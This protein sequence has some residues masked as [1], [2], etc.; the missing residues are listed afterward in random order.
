MLDGLENIVAAL[1]AADLSAA[2]GEP[3]VSPGSVD[4]GDFISL[5]DISSVLDHGLLQPPYAQLVMQSTRLP[6]GKLT[7]TAK[8]SDGGAVS[9]FDGTR[10]S[11]ALSDGYTLKLNQVHHWHRRTAAQVRSLEKHLPA[12]VKP[13]VFLTPAAEEALLPH[14]D[15]SHVLVVQLEGRKEWSLW[16]PTAET[17]SSY[18]LDVDVAN[19]AQHPVL[20]PGD[21][22]YLPHGF[23]HAARAVGGPSLHITFTLTLPTP[24]TIVDTLLAE[25]DGRSRSSVQPYTGRADLIRDTTEGMRRAILE[26]DNPAWFAGALA[27]QRFEQESE[28]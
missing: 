3:V 27:R 21:V 23:P 6:D 14:R 1:S 15:A 19:P 17:R 4:V 16:K 18:G 24:K 22:M 20:C 28:T 9:Y 13:F 10:V 26:A 25:I 2:H 7:A 5:D 8:T 11:K 12:A